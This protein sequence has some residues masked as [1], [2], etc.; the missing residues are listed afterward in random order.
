MIMYTSGTTGRPKGAVLS[1]RKT[2]FNSLNAEMFFELS[3]NDVMLIVTP[4]FHSGALF[5][6]ASPCLYKGCT[7]VLHESFAPRRCCGTSR[8]TG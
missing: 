8:R 6:Q 1:H 2:F 5:I 3:S 4:L 7:I